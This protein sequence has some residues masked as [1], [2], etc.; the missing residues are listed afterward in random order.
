MS[1][2]KSATAVALV[3]AL[4]V[5][6]A[7]IAGVVAL[8][9]GSGEAPAAPHDPSVFNA[10][11][12]QGQYLARAGNCATCHTVEGGKTFAGGLPFHT[13]FGVLYSTNITMDEQ[14]GIG[15]W[16]F[17]DFHRSMKQGVRPDG[18]HLYPAFPYTAFAKM[19]D[20]DIASLW[21]YL[22]TIEPVSAPAVAN[23]LDFPYNLRALLG[24]WKTLF[25]DDATFEPVADRSEQWN[26]GAYLVEGPGHCGACHT[27]RNPLG[28]E[29]S[30]LALTGGVY[31]DRVKL[32]GHRN[33]AAPNITPSGVGLAAW[34]EADIVAYLKHGQS[35][36]AVVHGPMN[37]VVMNST[38]H[39]DDADLQAVATY[40]KGVPA[41]AQPVGDRPSD[42]ELAVGKIVYTV[43][44]G[45][46]HLPTGLG[47]KGLG[48]P[49]AGN[50]IVQAPDPA[51]LLNVILYGPH[52]P[53]PPFVAER[54]R[55]K[56]FGKRLSDDDIAAVATYLRSS[57]GNSA[58]AVTPEQVK[59]QR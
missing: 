21:L 41:N 35:E 38:R 52:L 28:A 12:E 3:A 34:S 32:G 27:P 46:C 45:S 23:A 4:I 49:L 51:S 36:R 7:A 42:D 19:T 2:H 33:W 11:V 5:S 43:H 6:I 17:Q 50:P 18:A 20:D 56:M 15:R 1:L 29:R 26:R 14:T 58:S 9:V 54:T 37:E 40:L 47:D 57:F 24:V 8:F 59:V 39:L 53:P 13:P 22:Q 31:L 10:S 48:V 25:H 30:E 55:M 16:S 44:C